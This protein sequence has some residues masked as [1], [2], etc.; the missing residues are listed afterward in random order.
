MDNFTE[1][2]KKSIDETGSGP[3]CIGHYIQQ[4]G[5]KI[6]G[7]VSKDENFLG[8][9]LGGTESKW[10]N[11][12]IKWRIELYTGDEFVTAD[13]RTLDV[14]VLMGL[15]SLG[16]FYYED[17]K[18]NL[19]SNHRVKLSIEVWPKNSHQVASSTSKIISSLE[20]E[21]VTSA[22]LVGY[23]FSAHWCPPCKSFTPNLAKFYKSVNAVEKKIEI[24]FFSWDDKEQSFTEYFSEMPWLALKF[25][26]EKINEIA[27][28]NGVK[29]IPTLIILKDG[30]IVT[31]SGRN[32]VAAC[33]NDDEYLECFDKWSI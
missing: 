22:P 29:S 31:R 2:I 7:L 17:F 15:G 24:I 5:F 19:V 1:V 26:H 32:D 8:V 28:Q 27:K 23:Y 6:G 25:G 33:E 3:G 18:E 9:N 10:D 20:D 12:K 4:N 13:E 16:T 30:K 14:S 21:R 11:H